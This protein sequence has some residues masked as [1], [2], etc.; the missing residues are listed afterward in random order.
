MY[1]VS[2]AVVV[3]TYMVKTDANC[4]TDIV[5][6]LVLSIPGIAFSHKSKLNHVLETHFLYRKWKSVIETTH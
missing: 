6:T 3:A 2:A 1:Y 4:P 5:L